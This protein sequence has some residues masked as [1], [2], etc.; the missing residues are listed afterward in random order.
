[1]C[2]SLGVAA[3]AQQWQRMGPAG[4]MVISLST[5]SDGTTYLGTADGHVFA[6]EARAK[7]WE[8]RGRI[9]QRTDAVI[10]R[11]LVDPS[12]DD[13]V[14]AALWYQKPG[15]GGG[16]FKSEDGGKTWKPLGL[17][18]EAVRALEFA[19]AQSNL[20]VAGT[21]TGVFRS[22]DA[23]KKWERISPEG[24]VELRNLD[25]LAID[26]RDANIIYAGTYHLP[27]KTIDGGKSWKPVINGLIDDSDIMS[28]RI[29]ASKPDRLFLS[30]CSGI[31]RSENQGESWTKLQGIPYAARRTQAIVQDLASP[32]ALYAATTEGLWV[33]QDAGESWNRT[34]P[35]D[36]VIN[37][38][39]VVEGRGTGTEHVLIGTESRGVLTSE[40]GGKTFVSANDG[41][42]HQVVR[43]LIS[44]PRDATHLAILLEREGAILWESRDAGQSWNLLP[45]TAGKNSKGTVFAAEQVERLFASPWGWIARFYNGQLWQWDEREAKWNEWKLRV[46]VEHAGSTAS[47]KQG[48]A[49]KPVITWEPVAPVGN[50]LG[51]SGTDAY[52]AARQGLLRC[53]SA[54][55]CAALKAFTHT[56][57]L[58]ALQVFPDGA[59][60]LAIA[61]GKLATSRDGGQTAVWGDIPEPSA[62]I[63]WLDNEDLQGK[64]TIFLGTT[65]GLF[66]SEDGGASWKRPGQGLPGGQVERFLR[67]RGI[68]A[69]S[70]REGGFYVS[71]D[72]GKTWTREDRDTERSRFTGLVETAPGVVTIGSQS[73]GVLQWRSAEKSRGGDELE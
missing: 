33:T 51:F 56:G 64:P 16:V 4:G 8:L 12:Q 7:N 34:T 18:N 57:E 22:V 11:L 36:W 46:K 29:D 58:N 59:T 68:L 25:S 60:L 24:D 54:R 40:A 61:G 67:A 71:R 70:L 6:R 53:D 23:G 39:S 65:K 5:G 38:V 31:Y 37:S 52:V 27:W 21:R 2:A 72:N 44:D 9:T 35:Q 45:L 32:Q 43:Q 42:A 30:A 50:A 62:A 26:P 17:E 63:L 15:A 47:S 20:I 14:Y 66:A 1:M 49:R 3:T 13:R 73:E 55:N 41:F 48:Q 10:S 19:P 69:A 28:L